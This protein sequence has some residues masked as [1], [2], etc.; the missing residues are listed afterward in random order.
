MNLIQIQDKLKGLSEYQLVGEMQSPSGVAPQFMVLSEINRRKKMREA[1]QGAQSQNRGTVADEVVASAGVPT[2]GIAGMAR[3]LAP[4]SSIAQN[5]G[6][7]SM[8]PRQEEPQRMSSGGAVMGMASGGFVY[9]DPAVIAMANRMGMSVDEYLKSIGPDAAAQLEQQSSMRAKRA[10]VSKIVGPSDATLPT[11][12]PPEANFGYTESRPDIFPVET[13]SPRILPGSMDIR[14]RNLEAGALLRLNPDNLGLAGLLPPASAPADN[15]GIGSA[16]SRFTTIPSQDRDVIAQKASMLDQ[17]AIDPTTGLPWGQIPMRSHAARAEATGLT[18]EQMAAIEQRLRGQR[19]V[20]DQK[21]SMLDQP[22]IDPTTLLPDGQIPMRS[23]AARAEATGLTPEQMS[24]IEQRQRDLQAIDSVIG[25]VG[26]ALGEVGKRAFVDPN[27]AALNAVAGANAAVYGRLAGLFP[28]Y[29]GVAAQLNKFSGESFDRAGNAVSDMFSMPQG[30]DEPQREGGKREV[31]PPK[32]EAAPKAP[33]T[34]PAPDNTGTPKLQF[35]LIDSGDGTG[36]VDVTGGTGGGSRGGGGGTAGGG[37]SS[38]GGSYEKELSEAMARAEKR[39]QQDK[40]LALAQAGLAL[41][42]SKQPNI[43]A[44]MGEAASAGISGYQAA[45]DQGEKSRLGIVDALQS[46]QA[47]KARAGIASPA[48]TSKEFAGRQKALEDL[49]KSIPVDQ[50]DQSKALDPN[51]QSD[52]DN[53]RSALQYLLSMRAGI[54][55]PG[56]IDVRAAQ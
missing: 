11:Q 46:L 33:Q 54:L 49:I 52:L 48:N 34:Q 41:M 37:T 22:T 24:V 18:P 51:Q 31:N 25:G 32:Q 44:A 36:A 45:R 23:H 17:I 26:S 35:T 10:D 40:W 20:I 7:A 53:A 42:S 29:E 4:R 5:S 14:P 56:T 50:F 3:A 2:Q 47:A 30:Q 28:G 6:I 19:D 38:Y 15:A 8:M 9:S 43:G 12:Y 39:T 55:P 16:S 13:P 1:Y 27:I 21:V